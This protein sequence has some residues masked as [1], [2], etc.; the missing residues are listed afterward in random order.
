[1]Q[2]KGLSAGYRRVL[3]SD[4]SMILNAA[5]DDKK[6][7]TNPFAAKSIQRPRHV[8]TKVQPWSVERLTAFRTKLPARYRVAIDLG[9]GCGLRQGEIF[10][11]SPDDLD[12]NRPTIRV[13]RQIKL[14]RGALIFAPP[15]GGK[16]RE[17]PLPASVARRLGDH[18]KQYAPV[19]VTL[20][21][22]TLTGEPTTVTLYLTTA[23]GL[24]LSRS[25]FN[26]AVWRP[27]IRATGIPDDRHNGMHVLRHTYASVL[28]DAGESIKALSTYL[29]HADPGFTLR[30]YTHLLPTSEDR[31]RRAIDTAFGEDQAAKD[32]PEAVDGLETA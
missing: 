9:A 30:T 23:D 6:I 13:V 16:T 25:K 29:G 19:E 31:T 26:P 32:G 4:V 1:M 2:E 21:W 18:A 14:V 20:P 28:L 12:V 5:V 22:G 7:V 24:P 17:V 10:A 11:V 3:F 27:A 8:P 15:K